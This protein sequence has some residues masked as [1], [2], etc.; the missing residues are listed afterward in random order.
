MDAVWLTDETYLPT[1][2]VPCPDHWNLSAGADVDVD[3]LLC[4]NQF[5]PWN[6]RARIVWPEEN[7]SVALAAS[8]GL[9]RLV[10][11]APKG[12][13]FFCVEPVSHMTGAFNRAADGEANTGMRLLAPGESWCVSMNF[14]PRTI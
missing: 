12:E 8:E 11:Y 6:R 3:G 14:T 10:V 7:M 1:E 5:E 9:E 4:D 13:D 2:R